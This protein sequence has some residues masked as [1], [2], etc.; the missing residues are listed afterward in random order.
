MD[1]KQFI[2]LVAAG[3]G[4]QARTVL[5]ELLSAKAFE[6]LDAKK[7]EIASTLFNGVEVEQPEQEEDIEA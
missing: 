6:S 1:T 3:E 5:D 2:D 7:Q 4:D